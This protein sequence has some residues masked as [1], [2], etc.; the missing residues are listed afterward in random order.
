MMNEA[1]QLA[2]RSGDPL[3]VAFVIHDTGNILYEA[4]DIA[5]ARE[6]Y[7]E[8]LQLFDRMGS[9]MGMAL[10]TMNLGNTAEAVGDLDDAYRQFTAAFDQLQRKRRHHVGP[11]AGLVAMNL[12]NILA[13][14]GD[15]G[16]H[17]IS[18]P[19]SAQRKAFPPWVTLL[20][21]AL[22]AHASGDSETAAVLHGA[23]SVH[24]D[25]TGASPGEVSTRL[26]RDSLEAL[27]YDQSL[28]FD[29][30][31]EAGRQMSE[32]RALRL[33]TEFAALHIKPHP[34]DAAGS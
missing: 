12:A 31:F 20:T 22:V 19:R 25:G 18:R 30:L 28:D 7:A 13:T 10:A 5:G 3:A 23:A 17:S 16:G 4:G 21:A 9:D 26:H 27:R 29:R 8:A 1:R 11:L 15:S 2:E 32:D 6:K 34:A 33:A 24:L 14:R